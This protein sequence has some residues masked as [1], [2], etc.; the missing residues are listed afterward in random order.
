MMDRW[1]ETWTKIVLL[2]TVDKRIRK[3]MYNHAN[4]FE[5]EIKKRD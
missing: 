4:S 2:G 1:M 3:L 5:G